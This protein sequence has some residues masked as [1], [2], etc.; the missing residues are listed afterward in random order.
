MDDSSL[1]AD[2]HGFSA[3][4]GLELLQ[5]VQHM[6]LD[7]PLRATEHGPDL[8]VAESPGHVRQYFDLTLGEVDP[9]CERRK[10]I[11]DICGNASAAGMYAPDRVR[12]I[13]A[14]DVLEE[15][16]SRASLEWGRRRPSVRPS[17][18]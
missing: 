3:I 5:N 14:Y 1:Q 11:R 7:R 4:A 16:A 8:F 10:P 17:A 2:G 12:H 15:I 18:S 9:W 13:L 6:H